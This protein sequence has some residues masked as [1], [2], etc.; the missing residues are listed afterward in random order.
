MLSM[1]FVRYLRYVIS[2]QFGNRLV[3]REEM[4][5]KDMGL[6]KITCQCV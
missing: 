3:F 4:T 1:G 6:D 5:L 2:K